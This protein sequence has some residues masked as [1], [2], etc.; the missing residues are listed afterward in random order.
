MMRLRLL[1]SAVLLA[2]TSSLLSCNSSDKGDHAHDSEQATQKSSSHN[3]EFL[4]QHAN[5][6]HALDAEF[7]SEAQAACSDGAN[8][9]LREIELH[10]FSWDDDAKGV[11]GQRFDKVTTHSEAPYVLTLVSTRAK[12]ANAFGGFSHIT[13]YCSYDAKQQ[14]VLSYSLTDPLLLKLE[15]DLKNN[16]TPS[17]RPDY[18]PTTESV[19]RSEKPAASFA[20]PREITSENDD[21]DKQIKNFLS[22]YYQTAEQSPEQAIP[23][24]L[25]HYKPVVDFFGKSQSLNQIIQQKRSYLTRWPIRSYRLLADT[26][27][28]QCNKMNMTCQATGTLEFDAQSPERRAFSHGKAAFSLS[29]DFSGNTPQIASENSQVIS[30]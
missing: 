1:S 17:K 10:D 30:R 7:G 28:Y 15:S 2:A 25:A 4:E 9:Y 11:N 29:V 13:L 23:W 12:L 19:D 3:P 8:D 14:K 6:P 26:V 20:P 16:T 24:M 5:D 21:F 18:V 27:A 22:E